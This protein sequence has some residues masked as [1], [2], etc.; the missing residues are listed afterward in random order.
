MNRIYG[1]CDKF[2]PPIPAGPGY[3]PWG[4][5]DAKDFI[6]LSVYT[7][8]RISDVALFDITKRLTGNDVFL[9]M[10]KTKNE[11]YTWIP[12]WPVARLHARVP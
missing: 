11:L 3:R 1:A 4:G 7:G 10:H 12:N 5:E 9:R 2:G 8:L 6:M